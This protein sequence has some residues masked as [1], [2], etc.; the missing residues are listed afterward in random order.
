MLNILT[1]RKLLLEI[2]IVP[3]IILRQHL[4]EISE[5]SHILN[6]NTEYSHSEEAVIIQNFNAEYSDLKISFITN[7]NTEYCN[8]EAN[9]IC[10]FNA[11]YCNLR[12]SSSEISIQKG[13]IL[14]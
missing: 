5:S 13:I 9:F 12:K 6:F 4:A 11:E 10:N 7:F 14:R 8:F 2:S 1:L 3:N